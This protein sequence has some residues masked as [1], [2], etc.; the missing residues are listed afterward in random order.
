[1][2]GKKTVVLGA[3]P[4][5]DR[6]SWKAV[7]ALRQK[8]HEVVAVGARS[9]TIAGVAIQTDEPMVEEVDTLTLYLGADRQ[10]AVTDYIFQLNPKRIIFNPGTENPSL[11]R[12][13]AAKGIET[14]EACTL[15]MLSLGNY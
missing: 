11:E 15:V 5:S 12:L 6:Y 1:M 8:G 3:S 4:N 2:S 14:L 13:A 10:E 7:V 9:G